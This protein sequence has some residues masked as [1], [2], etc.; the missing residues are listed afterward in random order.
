MGQHGPI[1]RRPA[2]S[3]TL[4]ATAASSDRVMVSLRSWRLDRRAASASAE[5][6][7][8]SAALGNVWNSATTVASPDA[9]T[10]S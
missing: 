3:V 4:R 7:G 5:T 8:L 9:T 10:S 6:S 1:D 2:A